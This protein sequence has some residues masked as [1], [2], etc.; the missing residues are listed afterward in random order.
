MARHSWFDTVAVAVGASFAEFTSRPARNFREG[1]G[2]VATGAG[3]M[4]MGLLLTAF[5]MPELAALVTCAIFAAGA[6]RA[7]Q[8]D[9]GHALE[10]HGRA[11]RGP[12]PAAGGQR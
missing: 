12:A 5:D 8:L 10:R 7:W 11:R 2:F 9:F 4:T 3:G 1:W 6:H